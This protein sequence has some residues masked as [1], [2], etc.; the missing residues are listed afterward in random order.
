MSF[1]QSCLNV[2]GIFSCDILA[3][4]LSHENLENLELIN[5]SQCS[6]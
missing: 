5:L 3:V 1:A 2:G 4:V 6:L